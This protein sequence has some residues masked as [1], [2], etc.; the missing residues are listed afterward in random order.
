VAFAEKLATGQ[1]GESII[2]KWCMSRGNSVLPVYE[3]EIDTGKGPRFFTPEGQ[4]VA[5]DMFVIPSMHWVEAK[6]KTVC[7]W[8]RIGGY[9]CTGIDLN[10]YDGYQHVE[11]VSRRPVWLLFLHRSS[12][13]DQRDIEHGCPPRCPVGLYGGSLS[14]LTQ[15]ESHRHQNWGRYGMVY[16]AIDTLS[17]LATL[18]E[19]EQSRAA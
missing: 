4:F 10:H 12:T 18:E 11:R 2:A 1:L 19:I 14:Y 15:H 9:W 5:P 8:Y 3:K 13:P 16:W 7:S 17:R 6:H